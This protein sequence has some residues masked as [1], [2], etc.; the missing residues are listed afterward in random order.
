M[1]GNGD[2]CTFPRRC[3][4]ERHIFKWTYCHVGT[5]VRLPDSWL[6]VSLHPDDPA[7]GQLNKVL[8]CH[9]ANVK[10]AHKFHVELHSLHAALQVLGQISP[11]CSSSN[12]I[13]RVNSDHM[14]YL[15][16][17]DE[18]ALPGNLKNRRHTHYLFNSFSSRPFQLIQLTLLRGYDT[19]R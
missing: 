17:K 4:E 8:R 14:H 9:I 19:S 1:L 10:L 18:W 5:N 7:T 6:Q 12:I 15:Y 11:K 3:T 16:C 2:L 13:Q